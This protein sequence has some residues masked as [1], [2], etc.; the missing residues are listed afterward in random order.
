VEAYPQGGVALWLKWV[1]VNALG[2]AISVAPVFIAPIV[3]EALGATAASVLTLLLGILIAILVGM[4]QWLVLRRYVRW[5][6]PWWLATSAGWIAGSFLASY[7]AFAVLGTRPSSL[8]FTA[9][10]APVNAAV[11]GILQWLVLRR[12]VR[13]AGWWVFAS[14]AAWAIGNQTAI[15]IWFYVMM[16]TVG[17]VSSLI[18]DPSSLA[19]LA[20][21][22]TYPAVIGAIAGSITGIVLVWLLRHPHS[23]A[24]A[25]T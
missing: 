7:A 22:V 13:R 15:F 6:G 11:V 1:L 23:D 8:S 3:N 10:T 5:A 18:R 12:H 20:L 14:I 4:L 25:V 21:S 2:L 17:V 24:P 9:V 16:F 19:L